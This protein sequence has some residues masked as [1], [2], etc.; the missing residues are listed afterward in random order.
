MNPL[1]RVY[2]FS[3]NS[4]D[5]TC[6][7]TVHA[8]FLVLAAAVVLA[9]SPAQA[10]NL[11][12]NPG[13]E[14]APSGQV[15]ASGWTYFAPPTLNPSVHDYWVAGPDYG[16]PA[17]FGTFFWKQ[18]GA[19]YAAPPTN[20]VAGIYQTFSSAPGATYQAS[21][22]FSTASLDGGGL[23]ADCVTWIE[24]AFIG[25]SSNVLAL[26]KS[27]NFSASVGMDTW[28]PYSVTGACDLSQPVATGDPY[29]TTYA[30]TGTVSQLVAPLGTKAVRYRYAYLAIAKEGGSAN[31]DDAVLNQSGGFIP[32]V[33]TNLFP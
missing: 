13:F 28:F 31:F 17:L 22:W 32:P 30:V 9:A 23:G 7:K 3:R 21:G 14:T 5:S 11:L 6:F 20:N 26:Y 27:D 12:V 18:W 16:A 8:A 24:V 33:I 2:P 10:G 1:L 29:F 15:V 25:A 4:N 19:L